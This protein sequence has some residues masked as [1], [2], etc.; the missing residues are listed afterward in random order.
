MGSRRSTHLP[1]FCLALVAVSPALAGTFPLS[2][3]Q[4]FSYPYNPKFSPDGRWVVWVEDAETDEAYELWRAPVQG[5]APSR[6]SGPLLQGQS[7]QDFEI[8]PDSSWVAYAAREDDLDHV[9]VYAAPLAGPPGNAVKLNDPFAAD[10]NVSAVDFAPNSS[11]VLF[12]VSYE[13]F[14]G[15]RELWTAPPGGGDLDLVASVPAG[16][17]INQWK[18]TPD[19]QYLLYVAKPGTSTDLWRVPLVGGMPFRLSSDLP[20]TRSVSTFDLSPDGSLAAYAANRDAPLRREL[21][22]VPVAGGAPQQLSEELGVDLS[23]SHMSFS[24]DGSRVVYRQTIQTEQNLWSIE[25]DGDGLVKLNGLMIPGGGFDASVPFRIGP[26]SDR[27]VYRADQ[28]QVGV[29]ELYSVPLTGGPDVK[30]NTAPVAGGFVGGFEISADGSRVVYIADI[31]EDNRDDLYSSSTLAGPS[32]RLSQVP[33]FSAVDVR[34]FA[35]SADGDR[36]FYVFESNPIIGEFSRHV[37]DTPVAGGARHL[38]DEALSDGN[39]YVSEEAFA[40][41]PTDPNVVLYRI[42]KELPTFHAQLFYGDA[43]VF[44]NG[45]EGTWRWSS[46]P[47][48]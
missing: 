24:P 2:D 8:S 11:R 9:E 3:G 7:I 44:C 36:V 46:A 26:A 34:A 23:C 37:F 14:E 18:F 21:F 33:A 10:G 16:L 40:A 22:R 15:P 30:I 4:N 32:L 41:S 35:L 47:P 27:V 29:F 28:Q 6:L 12:G 20:A 45:F 42:M 17:H 39:E 31:E 25:P 38:V 43:C 48:P 1:G 5:G 19:S 13:E